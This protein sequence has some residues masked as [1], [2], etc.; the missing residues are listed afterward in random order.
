MRITGAKTASPYFFTHKR[1]GYNTII[2]H[3]YYI[4]INSDENP[5]ENLYR[6]AISKL[7]HISFSIVN[8]LYQS[9]NILNE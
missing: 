2:Q 5:L 8:V 6:L 3:T 1:L 7:Q 4:N 9:Y